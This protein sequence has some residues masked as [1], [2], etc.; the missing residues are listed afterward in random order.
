MFTLGVARTASLLSEM[1]WLKRD[2]RIKED[3]GFDD[4]YWHRAAKVLRLAST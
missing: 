3:L 2:C 4:A 1:N